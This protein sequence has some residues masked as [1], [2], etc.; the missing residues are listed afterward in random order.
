MVPALADVL[1]GRA[2]WALVLGD[3]TDAALGLA[4]LPDGSVDH[5]ITDPP[6]SEALYSRT[7][8]NRGRNDLRTPNDVKSARQLA[9]RR[10]GS[11]DAI[12]DEVGAHVVRVARRWLVVFHDVEIGG[13]WRATMGARYV[14]TGA[15]VKPDPMPQ[16]SGD[17][18]GQG[19]EQCSI[20]Y[21]S[22]GRMRWNGGGRAAVWIVGREQ[23]S[24]PD[25]PCPKP[26]RLME[27]L[28]RDFTEPDEVV[29]DPF[30]GSGTTGV[31][32]LRLGRRFI[33]WERDPAYH[34]A[35]TKRIAETREQRD[36][37][38]S[39]TGKREQMGLTLDQVEK[40]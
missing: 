19:F 3:C 5:V 14:R 35:A 28:I 12:L 27:M 22:S 32:C 37:L 24:R 10:I 11:I 31:A 26:L 1:A 6:Y 16:I 34:A 21:G 38:A 36:L 8:T 30:T 40:P 15:W 39:S 33:G 17:R 20:G 18:P 9:D 2:R 25:H 23:V 13:R 4:A 29:V 7:R